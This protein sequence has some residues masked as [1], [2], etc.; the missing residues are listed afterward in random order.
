MQ[1]APNVSF[2]PRITDA[3]RR[4]NDGF[5]QGQKTSRF[6]AWAHAKKSNVLCSPAELGH[7]LD[8]S[9]PRIAAKSS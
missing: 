8:Q 6:I 4:T 5:D 1:D 7:S 3:A 9:D 2:E